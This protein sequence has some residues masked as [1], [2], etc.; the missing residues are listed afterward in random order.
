ME[1][2]DTKQTIFTS[3]KTLL[4]LSNSFQLKDAGDKSVETVYPE[5]FQSTQFSKSFRAQK[6]KFGLD[7][8]LNETKSSSSTFFNAVDTDNIGLSGNSLGAYYTIVVGDSLPIH[9]DY[10]MNAGRLDIN[11]PILV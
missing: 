1:N 6:F 3:N 10:D 7:A 8:V 9:C 11:D 5:S 4:A 2:K